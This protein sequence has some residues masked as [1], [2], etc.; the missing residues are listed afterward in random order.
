MMS[1]NVVTP[2]QIDSSR[3]ALC[4]QTSEA[5]LPAATNPQITP[6]MEAIDFFRIAMSNFLSNA[7]VGPDGGGAQGANQTVEIAG[8]VNPDDPKLGPYRQVSPSIN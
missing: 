6:A 5:S 1:E 8:C 4:M 2:S 3:S 7:M